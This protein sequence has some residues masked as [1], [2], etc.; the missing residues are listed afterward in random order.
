MD[1]GAKCCYQHGFKKNTLCTYRHCSWIQTHLKM[2]FSVHILFQGPMLPISLISKK[3][4]ADRKVTFFVISPF[5]NFFLWVAH[6][7]E[8]PYEMKT[9]LTIICKINF[10]NCM[11]K[12]GL[13]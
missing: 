9:L 13:Y 5:V 3:F 12:A 10:R 6:K 1:F 2:Q 11:D 7:I 8:L 4:H